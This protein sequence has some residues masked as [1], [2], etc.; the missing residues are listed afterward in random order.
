MGSRILPNSDSVEPH[1]E[2][3]SFADP[4]QLFWGELV[5]GNP[6]AMLVEPWN[7][8]RLGGRGA[9]PEIGYVWLFLF[10]NPMSDHLKGSS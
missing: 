7:K 8:L 4:I 3:Q 1:E 9:E 6:D 2:A 10:S 5:R